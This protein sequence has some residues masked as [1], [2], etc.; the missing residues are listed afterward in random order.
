MEN[1][2]SRNKLYI[3]SFI[4]SLLALIISIFTFFRTGG[5]TDIIKQITV[6]RNDIN[7]FKLQTQIRMENCSL[8]FDAMG[9]LT[10]SVDSLK[11]GNSVAADSLI[12]EGIGRIKIVE[13]KL[14]R[15]KCNHL[16]RI[17]KDIE[18]I[19]QGLPTDGVKVLSDLE[20]QLIL[21]RIFAESL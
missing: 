20:Y 10:A 14:Q 12:K 19:V 2:V 3:L 16:M 8:L 4:F 18:N 9:D 7:S 13:K 1:R 6:M 11:A 21:L 5:K 17:R 15:K